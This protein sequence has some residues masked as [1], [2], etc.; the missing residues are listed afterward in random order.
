MPIICDHAVQIFRYHGGQRTPSTER[1]A[2]HKLPILG[3]K[4][5]QLPEG[6]ASIGSP[7]ELE[8]FGRLYMKEGGMILVSSQRQPVANNRDRRLLKT[9]PATYGNPFVKR[10]RETP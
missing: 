1:A 7:N 5:D 9:P 8:E 2:I 4:F 6:L 10:K 3:R